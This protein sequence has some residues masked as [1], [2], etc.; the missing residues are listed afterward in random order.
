MS[1]I[2]IQETRPQN[3]SMGHNISSSFFKLAKRPRE[4]RLNGQLNLWPA[5]NSCDVVRNRFTF[6]HIL[7]WMHYISRV[8]DGGTKTVANAYRSDREILV[9]SFR[10]LTDSQGTAYSVKT[11]LI[12]FRTI[13]PTPSFR[14][15]SIIMDGYNHKLTVIKYTSCKSLWPTDEPRLTVT[16]TS[17]T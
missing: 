17:W 5:D 7:H 16:P 2:A 8:G 14:P 11:V 13:I 9:D 12:L 15:E 6:M 3:L 4:P 1:G 10:P